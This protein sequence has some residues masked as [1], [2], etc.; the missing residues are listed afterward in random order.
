MRRGSDGDEQRT[1]SDGVLGVGTGGQGTGGGGELQTV[2]SRGHDRMASWVGEARAQV[3]EAQMRQ[4][5]GLHWVDVTSSEVCADVGEQCSQEMGG[6]GD[7]RE[8]G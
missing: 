5:V 3:G 6:G 8:T 1:G 2:M 7:T 4:V